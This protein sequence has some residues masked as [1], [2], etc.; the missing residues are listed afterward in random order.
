MPRHRSRRS[1]PARRPRR[2]PAEYR[3]VLEPNRIEKQYWRDLWRYR[4]LFWI[5]AWR[6]IAVRYKQTAIGVGWALIRP[7]LTM[8]V[9]TLVFG[10]LARLPSEG[11]APYAVL[12]FSGL[13][14]WQFFSTALSSCADS[15][16]DNAN[17]LTK[18]YFPRLIVPAAAV[19]SS[20]VDALIALAILAGLMLWF[21]WWPSWRV[22]SLPFWMI[23]A[24]AASMGPGLWLASLNVQYRDFRYV[25]PFLVQFGLYVSPV[26]FS[27]ALVPERWQ[28]LYALNPMV[29]VIEGFRWAIIGKGAMLNPAGFWLSMAI[30]ALLLVTGVR[31]FRGMEKR[32]ADVI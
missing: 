8:L 28:L 23:L 13:L 21:Q 31:Q 6:D 29:G 22:L 2:P 11:E 19:I 32:F 17:L 1:G 18:V 15:L 24:F 5:L 26:G 9:F 12:V 25:V 30:V 4:E 3:L 20:F 10:R 16:V 27:S 7:L 14:P